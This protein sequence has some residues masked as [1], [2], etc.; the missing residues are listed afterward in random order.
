MLNCGTKTG[1]F[2]LSMGHFVADYYNTFLP[3]L[4]PFIMVKLDMSLTMCGV[5]VM[6]L[7]FMASTIQ[8][9]IGYL[10][11]R[12]NSSHLLLAVIPLCGLLICMAGYAPNKMVLF[13]LCALLGLT[14]AFIHPVGSALLS[15]VGD[16]KNMGRY[17]SFY[18]VG[19]NFGCAVAPIVVMYFLDYF[20]IQALPLLAI[21]AVFLGGVF[22]VTGLYKLPSASAKKS[23]DIEDV[24]FL[25]IFRNRSVVMLNAAMGLRCCTHVSVSTFLPMI[26]L[27]HGY[28]NMMSGTMLSVFLLGS[29]MGGF[30]G[31]EL[32]DRFGHKKVMIATLSLTILPLVFFFMNP[33]AGLGSM[34]ALFLGGFFLQAPQ[35]S[36]IVWTGRL[37][38]KYIGVASG[39]MMGLCFGLGSMGAALT[40]LLGDY[41]GLEHALLL[42]ILPVAVSVLLTMQTPYTRAPQ[43][44]RAGA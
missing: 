38:P 33:A 44:S 32:G 27:N 41:I 9:F 30:V 10:T 22:Y 3:V 40:A 39:M 17:M 31:G 25:K 16:I 4:L 42:S 8:P 2:C 18:I 26:M 34:L 24:S 12:H 6:V 11:D 28:S 43:L 36:S 13:L 20:D 15:K 7:A 1:I 14:I 19:G 5:L 37:M 29:A 21:P 35:P 23:D